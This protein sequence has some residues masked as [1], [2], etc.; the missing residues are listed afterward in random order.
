[1]NSDSWSWIVFTFLDSSF[2]GPRQNVRPETLLLLLFLPKG[3]EEEKQEVWS[4]QYPV[5]LQSRVNYSSLWFRIPFKNLSVY[6][7]IYHGRKA[8]QWMKKRNTFGRE[9]SWLNAD[10]VP[11]FAW[12]NIGKVQ[13]KLNKIAG[14]HPRLE[15]NA[16]RI[17]V[18]SDTAKLSCS[19][20]VLS[21][22]VNLGFSVLWKISHAIAIWF[23]IPVV[24]L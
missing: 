7:A 12:G 9:R 3:P 24:S 10:T 11:K 5:S 15:R 17:W 23:V 18:W 1:M 20:T 6:E 13:K 8:D 22:K 19:I 2:P 4:C 16:S 21:L 14:V